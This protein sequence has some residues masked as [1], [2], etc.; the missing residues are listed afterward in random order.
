MIVR[1]VEALGR[2]LDTEDGGHL[3][4]GVKRAINIVRIEEKRDGVSYDAPPDRNLLVQ[5]EE[6]ALASAIDRA[7]AQ[8]KMAVDAEDFEAAMRAIAK[9]RGPIDTF[10]DRVTVNADDPSFRE[11]RLK[12]LNRIRAATLTVADFSRI[13]G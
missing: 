13:E 8:A 3:L 5:G 9:L 12:L 7:E 6:K 11:N 2:F 10:F 1:R 4:A